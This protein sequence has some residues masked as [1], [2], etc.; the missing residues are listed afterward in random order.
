MNLG[1][2]TFASRAADVLIYGVGLAAILV[3]LIPFLHV[4]AMSLSDSLLVS[5]QE[6]YLIPRGV[7][8]GAYRLVL[9]NKLFWTSYRNTLWIVGVGT[10]VNLIMTLACAYPLSRRGFFLRRPVMLIITVTMFFSGGLVPMF[11]QINRLGLY[12]SRWALILPGAISTYNLIVCRTFFEGIPDSLMESAKLDG[13]NDLRI[14]WSIVLPV[15][16]AIIA[17]L[18]LFYAVGHW[19]SYFPAMLYLPNNKLQ[20]VQ[21]YLV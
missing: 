5:K 1:K 3:T 16:Q 8:L 2:K 14:L 19:N 6:I 12:N 17:V 7:H 11:I 13:A 18:V 4:V 15:S 9:E 20:P 10:L 21:V